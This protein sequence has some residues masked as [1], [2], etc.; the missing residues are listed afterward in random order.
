MKVVLD[1]NDGLG[2][3][4]VVGM[5][6]EAGYEVADRGAPTRMTDDEAV[7]PVDGECYIILDGPVEL[8]RARLAKAGRD[9][10]EQYHTEADL[11]HYRDQFLRV[12]EQL[13]RCELVSAAGTPD[14]V[15]DRCLAALAKLGV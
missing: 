4:T 2:K 7:L 13:P 10:G 1:G 3:S 6:R 11:T 15:F 5:L 9:L 12:A 8:S 14:K